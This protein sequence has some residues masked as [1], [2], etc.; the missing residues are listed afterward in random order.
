MVNYDSS[1]CSYN[2]MINK[3]KKLEETGLCYAMFQCTIQNLSKLVKNQIL[4]NIR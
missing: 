3:T 2:Q 1:K 4:V